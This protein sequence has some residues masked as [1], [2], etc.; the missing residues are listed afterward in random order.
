MSDHY[1]FPEIDDYCQFQV[2]SDNGS[3]SSLLRS[4][5]CDEI[6]LKHLRGEGG[7]GGGIVIF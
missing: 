6:Q 1:H 2:L 5:P 4:P 3:G 7:G